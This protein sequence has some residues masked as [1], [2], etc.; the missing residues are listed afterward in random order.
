MTLTKGHKVCIREVITDLVSGAPRHAV[1]RSLRGRYSLYRRSLLLTLFL[2]SHDMLYIGL[3]KVAIVCIG[4][5]IA[6]S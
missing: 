4:E 2:G 1:Y 5:V 3:Y 6:V